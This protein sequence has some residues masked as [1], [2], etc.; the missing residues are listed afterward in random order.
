MAEQTVRSPSPLSGD[1]LETLAEFVQLAC[2]RLFSTGAS[3]AL[4]HG[5][6]NPGNILVGP[7]H[8]VIL[9]WAEASVGHPFFTLENLLAIA[10]GLHKDNERLQRSVEEAYLARWAGVYPQTTLAEIRRWAPVPAIF[11]FSLS[12]SGL[13]QGGEDLSS[14][15]KRLLRSMARR[16]F[17]HMTKVS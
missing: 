15:M 7:D 16:M 4:N 3:D 6:L 12:C 8:A 13:E 14:D 17:A 5:D 10:H 1:E 9:D 11:A 2:D